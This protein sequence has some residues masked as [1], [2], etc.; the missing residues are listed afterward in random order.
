MKKG[1]RLTACFMIL[2]LLLTLA[3]CGGGGSGG[4]GTATEDNRP[5]RDKV[6]DIIEA[7]PIA[8]SGIPPK[9]LA[10][11]TDVAKGLPVE[12][13]TSVRVAMSS[14]TMGSPFFTTMQQGVASLAAEYGYDFDLQISDFNTEVG[15]QQ[16]DA[17]ITQG[18]D[19]ILANVDVQAAAPTFK[20]AADAGIPVIATSNQPVTSDTNV[21]TCI[22]SGSY[23]SGWYVGEYT[24]RKL[25][26]P[27]MV[28]NVGFVL[29]QLGSGDT[30]SRSNGFISGFL[31]A[32]R[33]IDGKPYPSKWEAMFDGYDVWR[34][35]ADSGKLSEPDLGLEL[36]GYGQTPNANPD[37]PG[38]QAAAEDLIVAHGQTMDILFVEC[39]PMWPG[40]EVVLRQNS[41][42]PGQDVYVTCAADGTREGM[43]AILE[44]KL[45]AIG[46][47][48]SSMNAIGMMTIVRN[49]F[50]DGL[51]MNNIVPNTYTPTIAITMENIGDFYDPNE[52][53]A[54][55]LQYALQTVD[56]YNASISPTSDPF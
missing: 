54:G 36:M 26:E 25:Y 7:Y 39:D 5:A 22:L 33:E 42:V 53:L 1:I 49:L 11:R 48:S 46:N 28:F 16:L 9:E 56:D 21:I 51:D 27:G 30:E 52:P 23:K 6:Y 47:N 18:V 38:G 10:D 12:K 13:K 45:M 44:G 37:A 15:L 50:A 41:I 4:G 8:F 32:A 24:A 43:E 2:G 20:R 3:G 55:G 35:F 31:Y 17:F 29:I 19:I 14:G 40:V 34:R